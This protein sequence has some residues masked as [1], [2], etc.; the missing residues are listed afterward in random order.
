MHFQIT[1]TFFNESHHAK[2]HSI[3]NIMTKNGTKITHK[4]PQ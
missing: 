3:L 1:K 2:L 4:V